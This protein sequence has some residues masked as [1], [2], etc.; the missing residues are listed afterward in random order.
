LEQPF[1]SVLI[2]ANGHG[3]EQAGFKT[4]SLSAKTKFCLKDYRL[5]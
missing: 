3:Y 2:V 4:L 1:G 5:I